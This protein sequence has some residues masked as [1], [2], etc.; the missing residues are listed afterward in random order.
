MTRKLEGICS[1]LTPLAEQGKVKGLLNNVGNA[2][3][4]GSLLEDIRNTMMEYQVC[5]SL[6]Y[7]VLQRLMFELD[8]VTAGYVREESSAYREPHPFA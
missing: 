8:L 7:L 5:T 2:N 4:L 3:M 1:D 6:D